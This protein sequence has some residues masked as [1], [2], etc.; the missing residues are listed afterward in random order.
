MQC[1]AILLLL[2]GDLQNLPIVLRIIQMSLKLVYC[3]WKSGTASGENEVLKMHMEI[4]R[5]Q[6]NSLLASIQVS[7]V[8][9]FFSPTLSGLYRECN[10]KS[11][12]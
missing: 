6:M 2:S 7:C 10:Q 11:R 8:A 1:I 12:L 3:L 5:T 4:S 9:P